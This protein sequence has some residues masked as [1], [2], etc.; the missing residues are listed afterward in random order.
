MDI[1]EPAPRVIRPGATRL[2]PPYAENRMFDFQ[3]YVTVRKDPSRKRT[4]RGFGAYAYAGDVRVLNTLSYA[5]PVRLV[6]EA[7]VRAFR[8]WYK[9]DL[10]GGAVKVSPRQFPHVHHDR[11]RDRSSL[12]RGTTVGS[13]MDAVNCPR[14][15][16]PSESQWMFFS[17][18]KLYRSRRSS[19]RWSCTAKGSTSGSGPKNCFSQALANNKKRASHPKVS[20][21]DFITIEWSR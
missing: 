4:P 9:S 10:L 21:R 5:R 15:T 18:K 14:L 19:H 6:A 12:R 13:D 20:V 11:N 7:T 8:A 17:A 3:E 2:S 1:V 16:V